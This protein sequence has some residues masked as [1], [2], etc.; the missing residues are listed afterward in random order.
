MVVPEDKLASWRQKAEAV[1]REVDEWR[2]QHPKATFAQIEKA[3]DERLAELR[4]Q[5]LQDTAQASTAADAGK[6]VGEAGPLCPQCGRPMERRGQE[7]RH[8]VTN[9]DQELALRRTYT[10]CPSCG[11][12]LFPP[13]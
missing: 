4:A 7:T 11:R 2:D 9:H 10:L 5:M 8:L 3:L 13:R 6:A 1:I 12:G